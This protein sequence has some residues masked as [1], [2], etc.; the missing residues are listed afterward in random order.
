LS[1]TVLIIDDSPD[2]RGIARILIEQLGCRVVESATAQKGM[3]QAEAIRPDLILLDV[4][5]PDGNGIDLCQRI[6]ADP[7]LSHTFVVLISGRR[8]ASK[9]QAEGLETG[10]DGYITRPISNQ[11]LQARIATFL[12]LHR[13]EHDLQE[14]VKELDCLYGISNLVMDHGDSLPEV[15]EGSLAP[16]AAASQF[17]ELACVRISVA[18]QT[19]Q[20]ANFEETPWRHAAAIH[21]YGEPVGAIEVF[22]RQER[23]F[24]ESEQSLLDAIAERMGGIVQRIRAESARR[25]QEERITQIAEVS[26]VGIVILDRDGQFA[27]TN[28]RAR[29]ILDVQECELLQQDHR[30][31]AWRISDDAGHGM[32]DDQGLFELVRQTHEPVHNA[33]RT[34]E[35][36]D[37]RRTPLSV[38]AAPLHDSQGRFAGVVTTIEDV[39]DQVQRVQHLE[40]LNTM[41][42]SIREVNQAIAH[43]DNREELIE[44]ACDVY[45]ETGGYT[46][47]WIALCDE[48]GCLETHAG[49]GP[50]PAF[51][52]LVDDPDA[53]IERGID[54]TSG[55]FQGTWSGR[56]SELG[57]QS[58][59]SEDPTV[60][61]G[62]LSH[63]HGVNGLMIAGLPTS[64]HTADT[65]D[66]I[67]RE[68][69][70]VV[71]SGLHE[72]AADER[73]RRTAQQLRKSERRYR[74]LFENTGTATCVINDHEVIELC[75][76][77]FADLAQLPCAAIEGQRT[78]HDFVVEEDLPRVS[79]FH[80]QLHAEQGPTR[81]ETELTF[82]TGRG[83]FR[84]VYLQI[85]HGADEG[86]HV[87]SLI[88]I[89][90]RSRI[91][92]E[93][94]EREMQYRLLAET[95][96]DVILTHDLTGRIT[97]INP[98][99]LEYLGYEREAMIGRP[100][101]E[102]L[103]P[104]SLDA[105]KERY[106]QRS[107]GDDQTY[108]YEVEII[109]KQGETVPMEISSSPIVREG[110]ITG[111]LLVA[112]DVTER[113]RMQKALERS[114]ARFR[115]MAQ[116]IQSGLLI[117]EDG[118]V[119]YVNDQML[120]IWG[121][122]ADQLWQM[123]VVDL[124]A[125]DERDE[126]IETFHHRQQSAESTVDISF[127]GER[128]DG[129]RRFVRNTYSRIVTDEGIE[130]V[131]MLT[132]D[133][134]EQ[135]EIEEQL[136]HQEQL[137]ALGRLAG[138]IAHDF[139]NMLATIILYAQLTLNHKDLSPDL[140][141]GVEA[142]MSESK[143]ASDLIDQIL[144]FSRR[145]VLTMERLDLTAFVQSVTQ[146]L[147]R[148]IPE[149]I[150]LTLD[151]HCGSCTIEADETRIQ[152]MLMNLAVNARDAMPEG[153]TLRIGLQSYALRPDEPAPVPDMPAGSWACL[154][155]A[156]TGTGMT[157][158]V[159]AHMFEPFFTTKARGHGTGLGLAQVYGI[160]KQHNGFVDVASTPNQGTTF[161]I[162]LPR[163]VQRDEEPEPVET[164]APL[165]TGHGETILVVEDSQLLRDA[166][167]DFLDNINY[168]VLT[169]ENGAEGLQVAVRQPIDLLI[170]DV[171]MPEMSGIALLEA[172]QT[173]HTQIPAVAVT[174]YVVH[175]DLEAIRE[176][177]FVELIRKPFDMRTLARAVERALSGAP[178]AE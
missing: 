31:N 160:V 25:E 114:E 151:L 26:P 27:F 111:I 164:E 142:I 93:L 133:L 125:P 136:R 5:L 84:D 113:E 20:M 100:V 80:E 89:T 35:H 135:R 10:A 56:A 46:S 141:S 149:N 34:L 24:L 156:D 17:P 72:L 154:V 58:H 147:R 51:N 59:L 75:N 44:T 40:R 30:D 174:G 128:E 65:E 67:F 106:E 12:R 145:S 137:A 178:A 79:A 33:R 66:A 83:E 64:S 73:Q 168:R 48:D 62:H 143:R 52:L 120:E 61:A 28:A 118:D 176:H 124:A 98:P 127:W 132:T 18:G 134:T 140:S 150:N 115:S 97:Y 90:E 126:L 86:D 169:A 21:V 22:Y 175:R 108:R 6:K 116:N 131:F 138:G 163:A 155:V 11:E 123:R 49:T 101:T 129:E 57:L 36:A 50:N 9:E 95:A 158:K 43:A 1:E 159:Q 171:V 32:P 8:I 85:G 14:R 105:V 165:P 55:A 152:Q 76:Q 91:A 82:V 121:Y 13:A 119:V 139:N 42:R 70:Q 88:D 37:G 130:R 45:V 74:T 41:L 109:N 167:Q 96:Q 172:L 103:H 87:I 99:G 69:I 2:L 68:V 177:G 63:R 81:T 161:R 19:Y 4:M 107:Q 122:P 110:E 53:W 117:V 104:D 173:E 16:I 54:L 157:D 102:F 144:D 146:V 166:M 47:V 60:I 148:T 38:N 77:T 7:T 15:L 170:T 112:R 94:R 39:S 153:G 3:Q 78:W 29:E 162:Y 92:D 23:P 71:S